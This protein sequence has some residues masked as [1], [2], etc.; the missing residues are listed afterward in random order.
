MNSHLYVGK[1][2]KSYSFVVYSSKNLNF[3][4]YFS[5]DTPDYFSQWFNV[6]N[7]E[8]KLTH[9][10][11]FF[12]RHP[13]AKATFFVDFHNEIETAGSTNSLSIL[14]GD[15]NID[16]LSQTKAKTVV[17]KKYTDL[18]AEFG[19]QNHIDSV[20]RPDS[21]SCLDH[22][23][24]NTLF[25]PY[26]YKLQTYNEDMNLADHNM[27]AILHNI[28]ASQ[29]PLHK[30]TWITF[31]DRNKANIDHAKTEL[32]KANWNIVTTAK[33]VDEK[34][35]LTLGIIN[36]CLDIH[37]PVVKRKN[38]VCATLRA[39]AYQCSLDTPPELIRLRIER[40]ALR[41][42]WATAKRKNQTNKME[43]GNT[44]RAV[45][46]KC[47]RMEEAGYDKHWR[48]KLSAVSNNGDRFSILDDIL[49][50]VKSRDINAIYKDE[51]KKDIVTEKCEIADLLNKTFTSVGLKHSKKASKS[52]PKFIQRFRGKVKFEF[53]SPTT[54]TVFRHLS[55][56]KD[57]KPAGPDKLRPS[58]L[59]QC[60]S[61][62]TFILTH[63]FESCVK[64]KTIPSS[65][66]LSRVSAIFKKNDRLD[67][68]NYRPISISDAV[69]K[70]LEAIMNEQT[71]E[72]L[73]KYKLLSK[74]QFGFRKGISCQD[75]VAALTDSIRHEMDNG[76]DSIAVYLDLTKAFD[77]LNHSLFT[78]ILVHAY[79]F[80]EDAVGLVKSFLTNRKQ[81]VALDGCNSSHEPVLAGVPQGSIVGPLWFSLYVQAIPML[82]QDVSILQYADDT[83]I[84]FSS[85]N[86][87]RDLKII[88]ADLERLAG[89]F[90]ELGL[91]INPL[92]TQTQIFSRTQHLVVP[93]LVLFGQKLEVTQ[94]VKYLGVTIDDK[95]SFK[96]QIDDVVSK[97]RVMIHAFRKIRNKLTLQT[98]LLYYR[99]MILPRHDFACIISDPCLKKYDSKIE[100]MNHNA[101]RV[102]LRTKCSRIELR[103][104]A[105]ITTM[106]TRREFFLLCFVFRCVHR[107]GS[108]M[109]DGKFEFHKM[110]DGRTLRSANNFD[111]H[112]LVV[113]RKS[114]Y[115]NQT[116]AAKGAILWNTLP[117][118]TRE[119]IHFGKFKNQIRTIQAHVT[120]PGASD[121]DADSDEEA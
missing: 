13:T 19:Y 60:A 119:I 36:Y 47:N 63:I 27:V 23:V 48:D 5:S 100:T 69:G 42:K 78:Q 76:Y 113:P 39:S 85:K 103:K 7:P 1:R 99:S 110:P 73:N 16:L 84:F 25:Q 9:N 90:A 33:S 49:G 38:C 71:L 105:N 86:L 45:R 70:I 116:I 68:G 32:S 41:K 109:F 121:S 106:R 64:S 74:T 29:I 66:K 118:S 18:L 52:V 81:F 102:A 62:L 115:M 3:T 56:C 53:V 28:D 43:V 6:T 35:D 96:Q 72:F 30:C 79:G 75:A 17:A 26:K 15:S 2:R 44:Y 82:C 112:M 40:D 22:V 92:K 65:W 77:C 50:K 83:V 4:Q 11:C 111:E 51:G 14:V 54:T 80:S 8:L 12:Y 97:Q 24:S 95:L 55:R 21:G 59:K 87:T 37:S 88:Q 57:K 93:S 67:Q 108:S 58:I 91:Q 117:K 94:T 120:D 114:R 10:I 46:N 31:R 101:L 89:G 98:A 107:L 20:T 104:R 61:Q 34:W